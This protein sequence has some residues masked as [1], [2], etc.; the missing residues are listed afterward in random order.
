LAESGVDA[1]TI[2]ALLG[3]KTLAM[4][5]RYTHPS[6]EHKRKAIEVLGKYEQLCQ[7]NVK[8]EFQGRTNKA[9]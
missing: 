4:T 2:V 6:D 7:K 1:Y 9:V 8:L 5:Q 3:H